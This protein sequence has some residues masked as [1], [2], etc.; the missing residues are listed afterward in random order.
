MKAEYG[1]GLLSAPDD[2][3]KPKF[4]WLHIR[5]GE[6]VRLILGDKLPLWYKAH[7]YEGRMQPCG[8]EECRLCGA[9]VGR[10]R[11]WVFSVALAGQRKP[12]LWE[13][14]ESLAQEIRAIG[15][16]QGT[17]TD[18]QLRVSREGSGSKGRIDVASHGI[19]A[20]HSTSEVPFPDPQ[21]ALELTWAVLS[22]ASE[23]R[24]GRPSASDEEREK[25]AR[26]RSEY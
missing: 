13:V 23:F 22:S 26:E 15:E 9:G 12:Y 21:E 20:Y 24:P 5:P 3:E 6:A 11:R 4:Q 16:Q 25:R 19:D 18:L 17:L 14:S 8:G 1:Y 10:Q 2:E 7:W